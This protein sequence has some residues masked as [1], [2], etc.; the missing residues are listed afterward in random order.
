MEL[1]RKDP[2]I[3]GITASLMLSAAL[4]STAMAVEPV[5]LKIARM[6]GAAGIGDPAPTLR[7]SIRAEGNDARQG[8]YSVRIASKPDGLPKADVWE[9]GRINSSRPEMT[10]PE[11]V[12][13]LSGERYFWQVKVWDQRGEASEWSEAAQFTTGLREDD[14]NTAWMTPPVA[15]GKGDRPTWWMRRTVKLDAVPDRVALSM[16]SLGYYE[17]YVNG[18]RVGDEPLAPSVTKLDKRGLCVTHEIGEFFTS[19]G[20]Q[21]RPGVRERLVSSASVQGS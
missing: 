2:L 8:A 21:Y 19:W 15:E 5:D 11:S 12:Q 16:V 18:K 20:K 17:L 3:T 13:L 10:I 7:W 1:K 6:S 4:L 14:W 9:S